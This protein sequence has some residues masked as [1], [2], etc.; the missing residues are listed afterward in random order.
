MG[1]KTPKP[2]VAIDPLYQRG[3]CDCGLA[4]LAMALGVP[5]QEVCAAAKAL[6]L[7]ALKEGVYMVELTRIAKKL[8][9]TLVRTPVDAHLERTGVLAVARKGKRDSDHVVCCFRGVI[10]DPASGLAWCPSAFFVGK[11][12]T[13][14]LSRK[15]EA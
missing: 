9:V 2:V 5:Y 1:R 11:R 12:P 4:S 8:G 15:D 14:F 13:Y 3:D 7:K 10:F 6:K